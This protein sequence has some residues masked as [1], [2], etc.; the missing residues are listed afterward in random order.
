MQVGNLQKSTGRSCRGQTIKTHQRWA[1][2][3]DRTTFSCDH[4]SDDKAAIVHISRYPTKIDTSQIGKLPL[5]GGWKLHQ[6]R[7]R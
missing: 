2:L 1:D 4:K 5:L 7:D 6:I 3:P